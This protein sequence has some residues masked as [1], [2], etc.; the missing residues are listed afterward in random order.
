MQWFAPA[1]NFSTPLAEVD[2]RVG[3][4]YRIQMKD[5]SGETHTVGGEYRE[6]RKS[7][8]LVFTWAWEEGEGC[9]GEIEGPMPET[10]VTVQFHQNETGDRININA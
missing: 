3:G 10:L 8:R 2:L 9:G 5:P 7:E 4:S 6:I 1:D